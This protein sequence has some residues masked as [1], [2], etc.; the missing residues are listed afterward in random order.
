METK[1]LVCKR[2]KT[3]SL[4]KYIFI[5][6]FIVIYPFTQ[7]A[8]FFTKEDNVTMRANGTELEGMEAIL[9]APIFSIIFALMFTLMFWFFIAIG[10]RIFSKFKK[11]NIK[12]IVIEEDKNI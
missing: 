9:F 3:R 6:V 10:V 5:G 7:F 8:S 2:F 12:Y 4:L 11:V 1:E